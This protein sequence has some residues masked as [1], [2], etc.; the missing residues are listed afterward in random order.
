MREA[1]CRCPVCARYFCR[2]CITEHEGRF[3]CSRCVAEMP[4][5]QAPGRRLGPALLTSAMAAVGFLLMVAFFYLAGVIVAINFG[6][7]RG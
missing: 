4:E 5:S 2:E 6:R 1:V 3:L 7:L